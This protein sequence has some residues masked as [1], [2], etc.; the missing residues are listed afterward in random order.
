MI[1]SRNSSPRGRRGCF[2]IS[3]TSPKREMPW[4]RRSSIRGWTIQGCSI[5]KG[6]PVSRHRIDDTL[7]CH[8]H[9]E[10]DP[11]HEFKIQSQMA[12]QKNGTSSGRPF[13]WVCD[14]E[15]C[16]HDKTVFSG[17]R[18]CTNAKHRILPGRG[19]WQTHAAWTETR[20]NVPAAYLGAMSESDEQEDNSDQGQEQG[21]DRDLDPSDLFDGFGQRR[22]E[23][24][25]SVHK[26]S[27]CTM[28]HE[29]A[30]PKRS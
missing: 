4:P 15:F 12:E 28:G 25:V 7:D 17:R 19:C 13:A 21:P 3:C 5:G 29:I 22:A 9:L 30:I 18:R 14:G 2:W 26:G 11:Q 24:V 6:M 23:P 16:R 1:R 8:A 10:A 27:S 20:Q